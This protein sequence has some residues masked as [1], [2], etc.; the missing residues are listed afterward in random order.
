MESFNGTCLNSASTGLTQLLFSH[1]LSTLTQSYCD[2]STVYPD[3][4]SAEIIQSNDEFDFIVVGAGSAGSAVANR[5][6]EIS[7]WKVLLIEA[8]PDPPLESDIPSL[9]LSLLGSKYDWKYKVEKSEKSCRSTIDNQC[10]W[11]RGKVLGGCSSI[12]AL[13]YVRGNA[14][15]Y[16]NWE[17]LGNPG[18][19][20]ENVLKYF[21]K[22]ESAKVESMEKEA[23]GYEGYMNVENFQDGDLIG[24]KFNKKL[25]VKLYQ[26][27][28]LPF[29]RDMNA[30]QKSGITM[31]PGTVKNGVRWNTAKAYLAPIKDRKNLSIMKETVVTKILIDDNKKVYGV[32]IFRNNIYKKIIAKKEVVLTAGAVNSPQL[33][34]LSGI[35]PRDHLKDLNIPLINDLKVGYNLQDH[36][37]TINSFIKIVSR[38]FKEISPL[39]LFY[40]YLTKKTELG[41][42]FLLDMM[43][44]VDTQNKT[45][46][47]PDIQILHLSHPVKNDG[48][49]VYLQT[50]N[51]PTEL[52]EKFEKENEKHHL[53]QILPI[54]LRPKSSGRIM[55]QSNNPFDQPKIIS[56]YLTESDDITTLIRGIKLIRNLSST[57]AFRSCCEL[58]EFQPLNDCKNLKPS[59]DEYFECIIR[60][61]AQTVY[62]PVGTCK[63]G[64]KN[65]KDAVVDARLK[66]Y[67]VK[68][69]RVADTS[70]MPKIVNGNTNIPA[71]MIGE[72][73]ADLI[74]EDWIDQSKHTEL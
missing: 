21:K 45:D 23:H 36:I 33:L 72:K 61:F 16:D 73:A 49:R 65:D 31:V 54:L 62:H 48:L 51:L 53:I 30:K 2:L 32:E 14:K 26:E 4:R 8:G 63:M 66:V 24:N 29:V 34:M 58:I 74:K 13:Q 10:L 27:L 47:Y 64:P 17:S 28:G 43:T 1:L 12:N 11:P 67:G 7:S 60:N 50:A 35:G 15:D 56:G 6:S 18:W 5:L 70:I 52:I 42:M 38:E 57:K 55:L 68:G 71:I 19:D 37:F 25:L 22:L 59:T 9:F 44:F 3:D 69:L 20:Y 41:S 40:S 46:D 39:D